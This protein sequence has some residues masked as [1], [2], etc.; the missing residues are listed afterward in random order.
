MPK[1]FFMTLCTLEEQEETA[2]T[3]ASVS[4]LTALHGISKSG[5]SHMLRALESDGLIERYT[6]PDDRRI[7]RVR[8]TEAGRSVVVEAKTALGAMMD[9]VLDEM[10]ESAAGELDAL[11]GRFCD[12]LEKEAQQVRERKEESCVDI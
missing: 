5:V 3:D 9:R 10:G 8:L 12:L 1:T 7:V 4:D 6:A 2:G 11:L